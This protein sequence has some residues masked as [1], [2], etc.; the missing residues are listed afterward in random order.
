[1]AHGPWLMAIAHGLRRRLWSMVRVAA[2]GEFLETDECRQPGLLS[3]GRLNSRAA[4]DQKVEQLSHTPSSIE[5][6]PEICANCSIS[7]VEEALPLL[8]E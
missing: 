2:Q 4:K 6:W 7:S 3:V 5:L 1:M 8:V